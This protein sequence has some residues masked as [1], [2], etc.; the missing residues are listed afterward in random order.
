MSSAGGKGTSTTSIPVHLVHSVHADAPF[1]RY[2]ATNFVQVPPFLALWTAVAMNCIPRT[3]SSTGK[4]GVRWDRITRRDRFNR[5]RR[6]QVDVGERFDESFRVAKRQAGKLLGDV[7]DIAIP[8]S[9]CP[10]RRVWIL[11]DQFVWMFL[12]PF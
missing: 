5:A 11:N 3:P 2:A 10:A 9:I 12:M 8:A 7:A 4:M 6:V 1:P